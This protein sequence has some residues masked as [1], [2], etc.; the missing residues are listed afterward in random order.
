MTSVQFIYLREVIK[1]GSLSLAAR[2]LYVT[3]QAIGKSLRSLE[4]ELGISLFEHK[5]NSIESSSFSKIVLER[6]ERILAIEDEI[7]SLVCGVTNSNPQGGGHLGLVLS[8]TPS[9]VRCSQKWNKK[10]SFRSSHQ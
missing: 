3:P 10:S 8:L 5:G 2:A 6:G 7:R 9:V 4:R 1:Y